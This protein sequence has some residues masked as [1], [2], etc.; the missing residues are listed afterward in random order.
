MVSS[1]LEHFVTILLS[2]IRTTDTLPGPLVDLEEC[3]CVRKDDDEQ[4]ECV[5]H[6]HAEHRVGHLVR[7]GRKHSVRDALVVPR[8]VRVRRHMEH[9]HLRR[10]HVLS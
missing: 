5:E 10:K 8:D 3:R 1:T 2:T 4:R 9:Q 7:V 6:H